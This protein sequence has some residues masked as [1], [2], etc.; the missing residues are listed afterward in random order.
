MAGVIAPATGVA[1]RPV[2]ANIASAAPVSNGESAAMVNDPATITMIIAA[3][4]FT[5]AK[6]SLITFTLCRPGKPPFEQDQ[7][8]T[9]SDCSK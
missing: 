2:P 1:V 9:A 4:I 6:A 8:G 3:R 5:R 7:D